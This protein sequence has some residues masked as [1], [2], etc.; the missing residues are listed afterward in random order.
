MRAKS[1]E[2]MLLKYPIAGEVYRSRIYAG[3]NCR[4]VSVLDAL[5]TFEWLGRYEHVDRQTAPVN[6]FVED[7]VL[8]ASD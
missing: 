1:N 4:V 8:S 7:F 5:V 2:R 6:R 3:Q